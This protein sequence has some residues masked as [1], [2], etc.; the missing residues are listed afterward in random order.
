MILIGRLIQA[1]LQLDVLALLQPQKVA[2][3]LT[4]KRLGMQ[5]EKLP[6]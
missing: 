3:M 6:F 5:A 1:P 2:F 4:L